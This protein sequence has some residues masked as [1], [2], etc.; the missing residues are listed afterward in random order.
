MQPSVFACSQTHASGF[1]GLSL[2]TQ[3]QVSRNG[4]CRMLMGLNMIP[5]SRPGGASWDPSLESGMDAPPDRRL[6][7]LSVK[8]V[9]SRARI[10]GR[11][12]DE[13]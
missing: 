2:R 13:R 11:T 9:N 4:V 10:T 8:S 5:P 6:G 3:A 1:R 7:R 12:L